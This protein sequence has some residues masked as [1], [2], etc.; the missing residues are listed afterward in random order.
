MARRQTAYQTSHDWFA[1]MSASRR[2]SIGYRFCK[3]FSLKTWR[4]LSR[5]VIDARQT[6]IFLS[7]LTRYNKTSGINA[8]P[9]P[10]IFRLP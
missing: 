5:T 7:H 9:T 3:G 4:N 2:R 1:K 6:P 10:P 8:R